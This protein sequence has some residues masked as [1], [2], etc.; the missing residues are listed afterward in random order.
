MFPTTHSPVC[1]P[2]PIAMGG[3]PCWSRSS[4]KADRAE[5]IAS[6]AFTARSAWSATST[7]APKNAMMP[8]P[9]YLS[10][11]PP[12]AKMASTMRER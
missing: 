7:G 9:M 4:L 11:V 1:R 2:M 6:A 5:R 3:S 8:S 12:W 10:R